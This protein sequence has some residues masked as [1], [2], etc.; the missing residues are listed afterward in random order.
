MLTVSVRIWHGKTVLLKQTYS[1]NTYSVK[2]ALLQ[3]I[4]SEFSNTQSADMCG[5]VHSD[6]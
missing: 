6:C 5:A 2:W 1:C 4:V 3:L